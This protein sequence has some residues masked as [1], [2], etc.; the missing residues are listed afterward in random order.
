[1]SRSGIFEGLWRTDGL[2]ILMHG[3]LNPNEALLS[4]LMPTGRPADS[5]SAAMLMALP[6]SG[7]RLAVLSACKGGQVGA[8]ISGEIFGFPWALLAGGA[9]S[10][11]LSR[12]DVNGECNGKWMGVLYREVEGG[13]SISAAAAA[14]MREMRKSGLTHPYYWA[15][16][17][18][19]GR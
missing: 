8:R 7:L 12:W 11:V 6:L 17:Q 10:T 18:V 5:I 9:E 14:A 13:A 4:T 19:S 16:M 3:D 15:A 2:H 1:L